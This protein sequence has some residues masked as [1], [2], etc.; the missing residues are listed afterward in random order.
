MGAGN[1]KDQWDSLGLSHMLGVVRCGQARATP[2]PLPTFKDVLLVSRA[3]SPVSH[4]RVQTLVND[5]AEG[6]LSARFS[7]SQ[8][9]ISLFLFS[10]SSCIN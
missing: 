4:A 5:A 10:L 7:S 1:Q 8:P 2:G 9:V 6:M 3:P